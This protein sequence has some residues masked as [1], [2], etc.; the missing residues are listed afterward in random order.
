MGKRTSKK[1]RILPLLFYLRDPDLIQHEPYVSLLV[2]T[3]T[4]AAQDL[5][6]EGFISCSVVARVHI[7]LDL[8]IK[9]SHVNLCTNIRL[10]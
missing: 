8:Q 6:T 2:Q 1:R 4:Q 3:A 10:K 7:C 5:Q 9:I